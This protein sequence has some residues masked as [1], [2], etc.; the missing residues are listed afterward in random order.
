MTTLPVAAS[1]HIWNEIERRICN[2]TRDYLY[3][4]KANS[5]HNGK[6]DIFCKSVQNEQKDTTT[7]YHFDNK[8]I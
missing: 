2:T 1:L 8:D 6:F 4:K 7:G 3:F 5:K